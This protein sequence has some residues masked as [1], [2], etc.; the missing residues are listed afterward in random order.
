[1]DS[2]P[3]VAAFFAGMVSFLS[4]CVLPL[5]PAYLAMLSSTAGGSSG[6]AQQARRSAVLSSAALFVL[7][8]SLVFIALGAAASGLGA[9]LA[10]HH[11]LLRTLSGVFLML[12]GVLMLIQPSWSVGKLH[13]PLAR[14][15][16]WGAP[17]LGMAFAFGWTPCIG[18]VLG[19]VLVLAA[20]AA[21]LT[22]GV[23]LLAVYSSGLAVPFLLVALGVVKVWR[24]GQWSLWLM[25]VSGVVLVLFGL[26]LL[27][28][29]VTAIS[30]YLNRF[31]P[32][33]G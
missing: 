5:V 14:L 20:S 11:A 24:T 31:V 15:G 21:S 9:L 16:V 19:S 32:A 25:R 2:P 28:N 33:L 29:R 18:P 4:P 12:F 13:V 30:G 23:F 10:T 26:L 17:L 8:F 7:G 6:L 27:T 22:N 1:M 3:A